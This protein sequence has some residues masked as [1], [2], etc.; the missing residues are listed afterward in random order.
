MTSRALVLAAALFLGSWSTAFAHAVVVGS[1]PPDGAVL[2]AAPTGLRVRF[3][4][5]V[6]PF[7]PGMSVLDPDGR[8]VGLAAVQVVGNE[9]VATFPATQSGT[10]VVRWQIVA[11]DTH[12]ARGQ[13]SFSVGART[14][15]PTA[16]QEVGG[17]APLGLLLQTAA[18]WL[19]FLGLALG[20][21]TLAAGTGPRIWRLVGWGVLLMVV[22]EPVA[23]VGQTA[24][25]DAAQALDPDAISAALDSSFGRAVGVRIGGA[26]LL[27]LLAGVAQGGSRPAVGLALS[28]G[29]LLALFDGTSAHAASLQPGWLGLL[30]NAVH[31]A[32]AALW[33]GGLAV[34]V[35]EGAARVERRSALIT[36]GALALT[37]LAMAVVH[38]PQA[39]DLVATPYG[40]ALGAKVVVVLVALLLARAA[41]RRVELS[42]V[43]GVLLLAG[44]LVSQPPPA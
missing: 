16:G 38:L 25:F 1:S 44:L 37:G 11:E 3:S 20:F 31:V 29:W 26:L 35:L 14:A 19:H 17:V 18:R 28:V 32:A 21:G 23:L 13:F 34:L 41:R 27:W 40:M 43:V 24:S 39:L 30:V 22:A 9:L 7:G 12:P 8:R 2:A 5:P 42:T 36:L 15:A 33:V 10:Y 4:E 6:R